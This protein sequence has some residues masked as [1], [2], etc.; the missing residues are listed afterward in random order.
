MDKGVSSY[1]M[2][3]LRPPTIF[4][5]YEMFKN[6]GILYQISTV[7]SP[8]NIISV[9]RQYLVNV[10]NHKAFLILLLRRDAGKKVGQG[11][12]TGAKGHLLP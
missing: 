6:K 10:F 7:L 9:H 3:D 8:L 2:K 4:D 12:P 11:G 5:Y 1:H